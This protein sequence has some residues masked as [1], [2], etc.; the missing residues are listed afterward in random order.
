MLEPDT[1]KLSGVPTQMDTI[2]IATVLGTAVR[3]KRSHFRRVP[4]RSLVTGERSAAMWFHT[5]SIGGERRPP[6]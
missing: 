4:R 2:L 3:C 5:E 6:R 1:R